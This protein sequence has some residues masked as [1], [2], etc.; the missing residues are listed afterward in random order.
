M[1]FLG[2]RGVE[3]HHM[4]IL[5]SYIFVCVWLLCMWVIVSVCSVSVHVVCSSCAYVMLCIMCCV[6]FIWALWVFRGVCICF[7]YMCIMC[8]VRM[9]VSVCHG[10]PA[11]MHLFCAFVCVCHCARW[12]CVHACVCERERLDKQLCRIFTRPAVKFQLWT[13]DGS[14]IQ[15]SW[16]L[17]Y[18]GRSFSLQL[19]FRSYIRRHSFLPMIYM[20]HPCDV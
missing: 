19:I 6:C 8:F 10:L 1:G 13:A 7:V 16:W 9:C 15:Q 12:A 14:R 3:E 4:L 2:G 17:L 18:L 11:H 20:K 5:S